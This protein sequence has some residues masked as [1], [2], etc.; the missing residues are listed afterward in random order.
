M[1]FVQDYQ[2]QFERLLNRAVHFSPSQQVGC[3]INRLKEMIPVEVQASG[4]ASL[5]AAV[6]LARLYEAKFNSKR[7]P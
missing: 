3:F 6:G 1:G 4:P 7:M 5:I 2:S